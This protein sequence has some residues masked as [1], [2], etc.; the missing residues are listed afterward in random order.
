V[1]KFYQILTKEGNK[2]DNH[3]VKKFAESCEKLFD[4]TYLVSFMRLRPQSEIKEYRACYFAKIDALAA[5]AG[6]T[7]YSM[8]ELI[9]DEILTD[10]ID[11]TPELFTTLETTT[12][13]LTPEG[14]I[15]LLERLD[16]WA[17]VNYN[18]ILQ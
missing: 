5:E 8:H 3:G 1:S 7:R 13:Y 6:E 15:A 16:L 4:G 12:K 10:M 11:S 14:W 2:Y 9:K 18:T 17:F